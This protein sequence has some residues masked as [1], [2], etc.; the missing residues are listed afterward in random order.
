M[1]PNAPHM[2]KKLTTAPRTSAGERWAISTEL[3]MMQ[4]TSPRP[5]NIAQAII[6][7]PNGSPMK[8]VLP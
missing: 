3:V 7:V 5:I 4:P 2:L 8:K 1:M 6:A